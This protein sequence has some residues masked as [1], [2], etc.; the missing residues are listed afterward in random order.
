[1]LHAPSFCHAVAYQDMQL[2][3][4]GL[5]STIIPAVAEADA[6]VRVRASLVYE[7][8]IPTTAVAYTLE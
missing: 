6:Y 8:Q 5:F 3:G 2:C 1:M 7:F 4:R